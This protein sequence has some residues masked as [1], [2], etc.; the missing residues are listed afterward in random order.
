[1]DQDEPAFCDLA[2]NPDRLPMCLDMILK[3]IYPQSDP[4]S[5][6]ER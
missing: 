2:I 4:D 5:R 3:W 6:D 1:M